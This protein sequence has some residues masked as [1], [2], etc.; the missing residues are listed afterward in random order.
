M[1]DEGKEGVVITK[2]QIPLEP[3]S[4]AERHLEAKGDPVWQRKIEIDGHELFLVSYDDDFDFTDI[5]EKELREFFKKAI[6]FNPRL[7]ANFRRL[8]FDDYRPA[9]RYKDEEKYPFNGTVL[10]DGVLIYKRG[11]RTD[12]QHRTKATSNFIG[13]VAHELHHHIH[14]EYGEEWRNQFGWH[15]CSEFPEEWEP[16]EDAGWGKAWYKNKRTGETVGEGE[17]TTHPEWCVTEYSKRSWDDDFADSGVVALFQS[18][19]LEAVCP[20]KLSFLKDIKSQ[21]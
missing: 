10:K 14:P 1:T 11:Q 2:D 7:L 18:E 5:H 3:K 12:I 20:Q 17:F 19:K 13:T 9:S 6:E 8:V 16:T 15:Y 4:W 21:P